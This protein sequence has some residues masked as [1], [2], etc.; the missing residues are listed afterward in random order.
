MRNSTLLTSG[1][2]AGPLFIIVSLILAFTGEG[3]DVVRHPASLL[4]LGDLGWI[5]IA[6]FVASGVLFIALAI[7]FRRVLTSGVGQPLASHSL[8]F[9]WRGNDHRRSFCSRPALGF[10]SGAP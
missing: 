3:F 10:P 4:A 5:Q 9:G 2:I 1:M 6:N 7:G 8:W